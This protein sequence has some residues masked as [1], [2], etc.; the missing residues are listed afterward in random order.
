MQIK[1]KNQNRMIFLIVLSIIVLVSI[2]VFSNYIFAQEMKDLHE[3][4]LYEIVN[5]TSSNQT[6][7]IIRY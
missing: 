3:E 1:Y 7:H 5:H 2:V 6:S 4:T